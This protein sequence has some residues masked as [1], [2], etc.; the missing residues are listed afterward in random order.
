MFYSSIKIILI[1]YHLSIFT[2]NENPFRN[3]VGERTKLDRE[4]FYIN[5]ISI[6]KREGKKKIFSK[7]L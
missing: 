1:F 3:D 2:S 4:P 5:I 7:F 6:Q